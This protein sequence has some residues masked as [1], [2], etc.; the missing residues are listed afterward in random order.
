[1]EAWAALLRH[2][3]RPEAPTAPM[4]AQVVVGQHLVVPLRTPRLQG[5]PAVWPEVHR[6]RAEGRSVQPRVRVND[7]HQVR[8]L[9]TQRLDAD[10]G[11][12]GRKGGIEGSDALQL[13]QLLRLLLDT[14]AHIARELSAQRMAHEV[15]GFQ[16][17]TVL[18][19]LQ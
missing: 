6:A 9:G 18:R 5:L 10:R 2:T 16:L 4:T 19:P 3:L 8:V 12:E 15:E 1:M 7:V 11:I 17:E 14:A 13:L